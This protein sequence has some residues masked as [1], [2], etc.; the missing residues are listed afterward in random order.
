MD[1]SLQQLHQ[2]EEDFES[3]R[4][5]WEKKGRPDFPAISSDGCD[6]EGLGKILRDLGIHIAKARLHRIFVGI[7]ADK[8]GTVETEELIFRLENTIAA[9]IS[10][11]ADKRRF[12]PSNAKPANIPVTLVN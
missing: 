7:D 8:S 3:L 4:N 1:I 12:L 9:S 5:L 11:S 6:E 10:E 2:L